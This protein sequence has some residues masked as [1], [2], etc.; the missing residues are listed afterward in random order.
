MHPDAHELKISIQ[1][2]NPGSVFLIVRQA[3]NTEKSRAVIN[4]KVTEATARALVLEI[5]EEVLPGP[6]A[7]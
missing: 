3:K 1:R 5:I 6:K 4:G 2:A 7:P